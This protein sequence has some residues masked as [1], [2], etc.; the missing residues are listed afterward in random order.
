LDSLAQLFHGFVRQ[1]PELSA[2]WPRLTSLE[3]A[4]KSA[5]AK[6]FDPLEDARPRD[7]A[8]ICDFPR[9]M[10]AASGELD[11]QQADL[12]ARILFLPEALFDLSA[13][14]RPPELELSCAHNSFL[15]QNH[16]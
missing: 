12:A 4:F 14:V 2:S 11:A 8:N 10:L 1:S 6:R 7:P 16:Q 3:Q 13:Q 15:K 9:A 5:L